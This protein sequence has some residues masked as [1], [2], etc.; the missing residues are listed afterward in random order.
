MR[1]GWPLCDTLGFKHGLRHAVVLEP[2]DQHRA[3]DDSEPGKGGAVW[4][5]AD[6]SRVKPA[7][8]GERV[9]WLARESRVD[10]VIQTGLCL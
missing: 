5:A 2:A 9:P 7:L 4:L 10:V 8:V 1:G 6:K 3:N